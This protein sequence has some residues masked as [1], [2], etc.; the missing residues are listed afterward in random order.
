LVLDGGAPVDIYSPPFEKIFLNLS[1]SEHVVDAF[2][3][4]NAG[5]QVS[6]A[7]T[8]DQVSPVGIGDY[9]FAMGDSIT[10]GSGDNITSD[11][12]SQDGRNAGGGYEPI[13]NN[14][15]TNAKSYPHTVINEGVG[16][17]RSIDGV[18]LLA[19]LLSRHPDAQYVL[20]EYGTND[21]A[22]PVPSGLGLHPGDSGYPGTFKDNMQRIITSVQNAG[23]LPYLA[24]VPPAFGPF[25]ARDPLCQTYNQVVA[26]LV[27][28]NSISVTPPD[29][30]SYFQNNQNQLPDGLHPNGIGY[31]SMGNLWFQALP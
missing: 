5:N 28:E 12:I 30:Y 18:S 16:G 4:D 25:S 3:I 15:L 1:R 7:S 17:T 13:L 19:S 21:A 14:L 11:D 2:L 9:Y 31:Q 24:K 22:T 27:A 29:F 6:G 26:E 23:K 10:V 8:H 20:I